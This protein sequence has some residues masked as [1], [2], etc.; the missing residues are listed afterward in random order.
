MECT[1]G[2]IVE[3][4]AEKKPRVCV[5]M[6]RHCAK[7]RPVWRRFLRSTFPSHSNSTSSLRAAVTVV[8]NSRACSTSTVPPSLTVWPHQ[9]RLLS[10]LH[11]QHFLVV[12]QQHERLQGAVQIQCLRKRGIH[13]FRGRFRVGLVC[14]IVVNKS[15]PR[16]HRV[17]NGYTVKLL[18]SYT[19]IHLPSKAS[20]WP[21]IILK[22]N[23]RRTD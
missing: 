15:V 2:C 3:S 13:H 18:C 17:A 20:N 4:S 23:T 5:R 12:F 11:G 22:F 10:T 19:D 8:H 6:V 1:V 9:H 14:A 7:N 21:V 16:S